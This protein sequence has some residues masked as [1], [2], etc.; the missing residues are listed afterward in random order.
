MVPLSLM[1]SHFPWP[2]ILQKLMCS[3][4]SKSHYLNLPHFIPMKFINT[5]GQIIPYALFHLSL[6]ETMQVLDGQYPHFTE[7]E[8]DVQKCER[9][10]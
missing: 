6:T 5:R 2:A 8:T 9:I 10:Y 4:C 1:V 3:Y 7:E